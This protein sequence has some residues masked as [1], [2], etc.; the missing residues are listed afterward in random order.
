MGDLSPDDITVMLKAVMT[1][2]VIVVMVVVSE[3][4][5]RDGIEY[6]NTNTKTKIQNT[7]DDGGGQ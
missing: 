7:S 5:H 6:R 2:K 4:T 3:A 1:K